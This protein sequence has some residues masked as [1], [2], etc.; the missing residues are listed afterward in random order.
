MSKIKRPSFYIALGLLILF[1]VIGLLGQYGIGSEQM[2]ANGMD[3]MM[4]IGLSLAM[5][6]I[7]SYAGYVS[8]GHTVFIG[9]GSFAAAYIV[10]IRNYDAIIAAMNELRRQAIEAGLSPSSVSLPTSE[11]LK[12]FTV[13][14]LL[15]S[16][17]AVLVAVIVGYAVLRLRGAFFAIA[18]IGLNYVVMYIVLFILKNYI[19]SIE[20][21][22]LGNPSMG[23]TN[24]DFYWM[25]YLVFI[26]TVLVAYFVRVSRL[27]YGLA[28]IREDE[29]AAEVIGVDTFK[30]KVVAFTIAGWLASLWGVA[31]E[32]RTSFSAQVDFSLLN[33]VVMLLENAIGGIGSFTGPIIGSFIY[34][35]LKWY[36][37]TI[38]GV[39]ALV[40]LGILIIL[41]VSFTPR[42]VVG[43]LRDRFPRL[44]KYLE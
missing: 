6:V 19:G 4:W 35:P 14:S 30:Y 25:H 39:F 20:G 42:G 15:A 27:G 16:V 43:I 5:A 26:I 38:A 18:T 36:T 32:F 24:I 17:L 34:Y 13:S 37:Q 7:M 40:I 44:R 33:S 31:R 29:D 12:L 23:L 28:A 8:F 1:G 22:E 9:I 11:V 41:V 2:I 10:A 21:Q 3:L